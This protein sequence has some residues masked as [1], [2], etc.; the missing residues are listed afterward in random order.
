MTLVATVMEQPKAELILSVD[1]AMDR[2]ATFNVRLSRIVECRVFAGMTDE[3]TARALETPLRTV[4]RE[5]SRAR[6]WLRT[7]LEGTTG[8]AGPAAPEPPP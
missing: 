5:W 3:E 1:R 6:A 7:E 4:Q 2:L 8:G